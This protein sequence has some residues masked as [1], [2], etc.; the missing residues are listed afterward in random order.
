MSTSWNTTARSVEH[1]REHEHAEHVVALGF[2]AGPGLVVPRRRAESRS[3]SRRGVRRERGSQ[4]LL[5][6][7]AEV[8]PVLLGRPRRQRYDGACDASARRPVCA[9]RRSTATT[10]KPL[11]LASRLQPH[12]VDRAA[13]S[14]ASIIARSFVW[15]DRVVGVVVDDL[16]DVPIAQERRVVGDVVEV[17][18]RHA[19]GEQLGVEA[20]ARAHDVVQAELAV[21]AAQHAVGRAGHERRASAGTRRGSRCRRRCARARCHCC[22]TFNGI[23]KPRCARRARA[24]ADRCE[25]RSRRPA[26]RARRSPASPTMKMRGPERD[27]EVRRPAAGA[28][29]A[30]W[31]ATRTRARPPGSAI[32]H[33]SAYQRSTRGRSR[34]ERAGRQSTSRSADGQRRSRR[35]SPGPIPTSTAAHA[36]M[37]APPG[38]DAEQQQHRAPRERLLAE[39]QRFEDRGVGEHGRGPPAAPQL[40][41]HDEGRDDAADRADRGPQRDG[42]VAEQRPHERGRGPVHEPVGV[43]VRV[44]VREHRHAPRQPAVVPEVVARCTTRARGC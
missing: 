40:R 20:A 5:V 19:L 43:R 15:R 35:G 13:R 2:E 30:R 27:E 22:P 26:Q 29:L 36:V 18:D 44:A 4:R 34:R 23:S 32:A 17:A 6:G 12:A 38:R 1:G 33:D 42:P 10:S 21:A 8:D 3:T 28:C 16:V 25:R 37:P 11:P 39:Q 41:E 14:S 31:S 7:I 24:S 9:A